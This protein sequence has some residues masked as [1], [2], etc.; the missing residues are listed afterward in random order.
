M[1]PNKE[2]EKYSFTYH[3]NAAISSTVA[4]VISILRM[5]NV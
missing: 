3:P 1:T 2:L 4:A 5:A